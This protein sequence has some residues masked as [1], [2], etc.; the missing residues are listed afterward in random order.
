MAPSVIWAK[1]GSSMVTVKKSTVDKSLASKLAEAERIGSIRGADGH[2]GFGGAGWSCFKPAND[3]EGDGHRCLR[4]TSIYSHNGKL[5]RQHDLK[6]SFSL[7]GRRFRGPN[8]LTR[9]LNS[10]FS[11]CHPLNLSCGLLLGR[12]CRSQLDEG[13][14][15]PFPLTFN[16]LGF[17]L[18]QFEVRNAVDSALLL[19]KE[20]SMAM[21]QQD[22]W[23][24]EETWYREFDSH[25][26]SCPG[27]AEPLG[28]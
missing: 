12:K 27:K 3:R 16:K 25:R 19:E 4:I 18:A 5:F 13:Q 11:Q 22:L 17:S 6:R 7:L 8:K 9:S 26:A 10:I 14:A 28:G 2:N 24:W 15:C 20:V 23:T 1:G 21:L